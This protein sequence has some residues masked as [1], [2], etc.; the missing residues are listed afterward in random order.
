MSAIGSVGSAQ[1]YPLQPL[2][3]V[4]PAQ[5]A[6]ADREG[7]HDSEA[8]NSASSKATQNAPGRLNILV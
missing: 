1:N 4:R 3:A 8:S 2:Q 5:S 6:P 7:D